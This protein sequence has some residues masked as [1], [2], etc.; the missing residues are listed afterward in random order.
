MSSNARAK[1]DRQT[2][3]L[4][5]PEVDKPEHDAIV[6]RLFE[7]DET[8]ARLLAKI[9]GLSP[10]QNFAPDTLFNVHRT[11][12]LYDTPTPI[13]YSEAEKIT[14]KAPVWKSDCPIRIERKQMEVLLEYWGSSGRSGRLIGFIDLGFEYEIVSGLAIVKDEARYKWTRVKKTRCAT[15]EVKSQ[16]PTAGNLI[17]QLNLYHSSEPIGF[18]SPRVSI[19]VGPDDSLAQ[20]IKHHD[21]S[22]VTFD[23]T[24]QTF[25]LCEAT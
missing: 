24:G 7:D 13:S 25:R 5:D 2:L 20:I 16:W 10:L 8:V 6:R 11:S 21:Y 19:A 15:V 23:P 3:S 18:K 1:I 9:H 14:G 4:F 12:D 17:R 22:L